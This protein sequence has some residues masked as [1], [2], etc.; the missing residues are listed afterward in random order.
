MESGPR[1]ST[2]STSLCLSLTR[3]GTP[4]IVLGDSSADVPQRVARTWRQAAVVCEPAAIYDVEAE[5]AVSWPWEYQL[6]KAGYSIRLPEPAGPARCARCK[7]RFSA[8][9]PTG[10]AEDHP[11][12]DMC[13]LEGSSELG[14]VLALVAVVR[15]FGAVKPSD[16]EEYREALKELGAFARIYER[17]AA[18]SSQARIFRIPG[19]ES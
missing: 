6:E 12:C 13:L 7:S 1:E 8:A 5:P 18:K 3:D 15:A 16:H 4:A 2:V 10:Y 17:V 9:G 19:F 11:I 14:M